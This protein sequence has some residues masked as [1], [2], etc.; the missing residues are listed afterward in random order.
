MKE[1]PQSVGAQQAKHGSASPSKESQKQYCDLS[2]NEPTG[3][4]PI[5]AGTLPAEYQSRLANAYDN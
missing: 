2:E 4:T 1:T 5:L 3:W